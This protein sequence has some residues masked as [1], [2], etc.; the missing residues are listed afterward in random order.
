MYNCIFKEPM[1]EELL[2]CFFFCLF[3]FYTK[4]PQPKYRI[5]AFTI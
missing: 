5:L 1:V 4:V 3:F 2:G